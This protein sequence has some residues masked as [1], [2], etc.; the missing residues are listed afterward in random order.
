MYTASTGIMPP[1]NPVNSMFLEFTGILPDSAAFIHCKG[2]YC[3]YNLVIVTMCFD[4][5]PSKQSRLKIMVAPSE[6]FCILFSI[7]PIN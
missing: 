7:L 2:T 3:I 1:A 6:V 5:V 4:A